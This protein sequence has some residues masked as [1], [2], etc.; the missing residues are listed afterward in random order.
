M[1]KRY[2]VITKPI[3]TASGDPPRWIMWAHGA[4]LDKG[5]ADSLIARHKE[6]GYISRK[7]PL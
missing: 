4:T 2:Q 7:L 5:E 6:L 3:A 1:A